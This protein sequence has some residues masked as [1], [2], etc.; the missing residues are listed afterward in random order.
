MDLRH[1]CLQA[2]HCALEGTVVWVGVVSVFDQVLN[3]EDD[4]GYSLHW[5]DEQLRQSLS[6]ALCS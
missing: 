3:E 6:R 1:D 4:P 5:C 2:V